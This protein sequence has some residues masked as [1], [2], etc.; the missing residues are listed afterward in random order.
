MVNLLRS[1]PALEQFT[2]AQNRQ[3]DLR[4]HA[5][6]SRDQIQKLFEERQYADD[7]REAHNNCGPYHLRLRVAHVQGVTYLA[8][9][10]LEVDQRGIYDQAD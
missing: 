1:R 6:E 9:G 10:A 7:Y 2:V 3:R 8:Y 4:P 5:A